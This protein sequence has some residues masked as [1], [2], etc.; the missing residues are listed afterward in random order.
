MYTIAGIPCIRVGVPPAKAAMPPRE[1]FSSGAHP[2]LGV[3]AR[4]MIK[5]SEFFYMYCYMCYIYYGSSFRDPLRE[6]VP[7]HAAKLLLYKK[8]FIYNIRIF[9]CFFGV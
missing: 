7:I 2:K 8:P 3:I 4:N 9:V 6:L 1:H 5:L